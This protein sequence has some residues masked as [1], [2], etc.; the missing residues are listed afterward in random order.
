MD[1]CYGGRLEYKRSLANLVP[2]EY[3]RQEQTYRTAKKGNREKYFFW[4]A[5][6]VVDGQMLVVSRNDQRQDIYNQKIE[7]YLCH[8]IQSSGKDIIFANQTINRY[9]QHTIHSKP[10]QRSGKGN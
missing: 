4:N 1:H 5:E 6:F 2:E 10:N 8:S 9:D 3:H 7:K